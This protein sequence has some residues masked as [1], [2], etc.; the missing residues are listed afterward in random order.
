VYTPRAFAESDLAALDA[1]VARDPFVTLVTTG[2][3]GLP[4]ASHLPVLY[5]RDAG[6]VLI[7][8]HWAR[9]N[10]QS[11]QGETALVI[12]HGPQTYISPSWYVDKEPASRVPTW[13]YAMAHLYG[14]LQRYDDG[15]ALG[16]LV[17][18]LARQFEAGV[19]SHWEFELE[20]DDH[21]T[22]LRGIVGFRFVP[23]RIELKFK[24]NQN[25]PVA[26]VRGAAQALERLGGASQLEIASLMRARLRGRDET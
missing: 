20:R 8:G 19:G 22:Q 25:H 10:P 15:S 2:P 3:D 23:E 1:L 9:P 4:F 6:R 21:T 11:Q 13:T 14:T 24:L 18:R 26:N 12:V 16:D 7:E 5:R 17:A